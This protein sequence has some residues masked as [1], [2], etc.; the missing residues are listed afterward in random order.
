MNLKDYIIQQSDRFIKRLETEN[1][2]E[3]VNTDDWGWE[4]YLYTSP[5]FRQAHIERYF[6]D[7]LMVLHITILPHKNNT[8]PMFGFDLISLPKSEKISAGFLDYSPTVMEFDWSTPQFKVGY[9]L[10]DWTEGIFSNKFVACRP[11]EDEYDTLFDTAY[12]MFDTMLNKLDTTNSITEDT[13]T[14][15]QIIQK[16]NTYC[17][18]QWGNKRTFGALKAKVGGERAEYFMKHIL[19]PKIEN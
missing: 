3:S 6:H 12:N 8:N 18:R 13:D 4:N 16:Q 19:F 11:D 9:E 10:P 1:S 17:Q 15:N 14:I 2:I 7:N 5:K